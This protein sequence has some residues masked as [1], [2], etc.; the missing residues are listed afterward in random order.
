[1]GAAEIAKRLGTDRT[2]V[3]QLLRTDPT[4]PKPYAT[5]AAGHIWRTEDIEGWLAEHRPDGR[6]RRRSGA[7]EKSDDT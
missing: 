5:L 4:F 3:N 7:G 2:R 6:L 1:M